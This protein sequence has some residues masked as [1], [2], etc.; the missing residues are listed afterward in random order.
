MVMWS[1]RIK[2]WPTNEA[3]RALQERCFLWERGIPVD[4]HFRLFDFQG[5]LQ[6]EAI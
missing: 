6:A 4:E 5:L 2:G 1:H 3:F